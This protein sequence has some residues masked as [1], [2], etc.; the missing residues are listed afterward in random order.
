MHRATRHPILTPDT[1]RRR[2]LRAAVSSLVLSVVPA[3][4]ARAAANA[5]VVS[6]RV[7]PAQ[8]YTRVTIE[9][10][11]PLTFKQFSLKNPDRLVVDLDGVDLNDELQKLAGKVGEDDPYIK[12]IACRA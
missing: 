1:A 10:T 4:M 11:T 3:G 7:W 8:A 9:S 6:V 12:Y 5:N 2:V